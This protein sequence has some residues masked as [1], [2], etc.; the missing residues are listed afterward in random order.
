MSKK[1]LV[2]DDEEDIRIVTLIRLNKTGYEA[3]GGIDGP[4]AL[5]LTRKMMPD[6]IIMDVYL[7]IMNGD[8][9]AKILKKDEKLTHIPIILISADVETLQQRAANSGAEGY[10]VKPYEAEELIDMITKILGKHTD[11]H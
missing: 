9:V 7:P 4:E 5:D 11:T 3:F 6:L 8:D 10:L 2:I 1:I